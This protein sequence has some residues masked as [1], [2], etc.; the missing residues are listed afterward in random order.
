MSDLLAA[1]P[2]LRIRQL[3]LDARIQRHPVVLRRQARVAH[4]LRQQRLK[5]ALVKAKGVEVSLLPWWG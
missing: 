2:D 1:L 3:L 4:Q 5:G